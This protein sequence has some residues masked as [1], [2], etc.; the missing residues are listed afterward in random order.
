LTT[1]TLGQV[2]YQIKGW[3]RGV[4]AAT[5]IKAGRIVPEKFPAIGRAAR[6]TNWNFDKSF[7]FGL[8]IILA[9]LTTHTS[10]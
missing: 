5:A 6:L 4:D 2:S 7:E 9:G 1:F 3:G 10:A 8:S